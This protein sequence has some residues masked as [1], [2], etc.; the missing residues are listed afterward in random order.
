MVGHRVHLG[1]EGIIM[2]ISI[3][4]KT[5]DVVSNTAYY[6]HRE[7]FADD[8]AYEEHVAEIQEALAPWIEYGERV[9]IDFDTDASTATVRKVT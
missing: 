3:T 2:K 6:E 7:E 4:F 9:T 8:D 5:P 1:E